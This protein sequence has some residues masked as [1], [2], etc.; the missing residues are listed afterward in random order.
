M[1]V[2]FNQEERTGWLTTSL[3][4]KDPLPYDTIK[5]I[6]CSDPLLRVVIG[7]NEPPA[8]PGSGYSTLASR[9]DNGE[10]VE[11]TRSK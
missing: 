1:T 4:H 3:T 6:F 10:G 2:S 9:I 11:M 8:L 5:S 7:I